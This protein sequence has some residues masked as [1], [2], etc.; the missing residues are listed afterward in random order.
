MNQYW[1]S[2]ALVLAAGD[3]ILRRRL[4][5]ERGFSRLHAL[6]EVFSTLTGGLTHRLSADAAL[7]IVE[8]LSLDLE[9]VDLTRDEILTGL[10]SAKRKGV[11]GGRVH[12]YLHVLAAEKA[13]VQRILSSDRND[14]HGLSSLL[15][16]EQV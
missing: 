1:D 10:R 16:I 9:F 11:R 12:D 13:A 15:I 4:A 5:T 7:A 6:A 2:S 3:P 8:N 14:F